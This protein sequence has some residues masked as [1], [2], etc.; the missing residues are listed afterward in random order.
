MP[1]QAREGVTPG[2]REP[3]TEAHDLRAA[4]A[5]RLRGAVGWVVAGGESLMGEGDLAP[6]GVGTAVRVGKWASVG[7]LS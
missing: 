7:W 6:A 2:I 3:R 5:G 4:G 1:G